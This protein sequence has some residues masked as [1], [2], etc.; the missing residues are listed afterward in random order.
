MLKRPEGISTEQKAL[1]INLDDNI[2]GTIVEIG[3]GQEVA[4]QFFKAGAAA[5]TIAKTSSAYDMTVSDAIYGKAGRY[6]SRERVQQ[7][8]KHE[9]QL[10]LDRLAEVRSSTSTYFSYAATVSA[11]NFKGDNE[12][13]GW[14]GLRLQLRPGEDPC[15]IICHV[16]MLDKTNELQSLALGTLGVNLIHSAFNH[17]NNPHWLIESLSDNLGSDRIEVDLIEFSGPGFNHVDNRITNLHL[18]TAWLTRAVLFDSNGNPAVPR[19]LLYKKP[20]AVMRGSFKPPTLAHEDMERCGIEQLSA[21]EDLEPSSIL[22]LAEVSMS[23]VVNESGL[24]DSDFLA[25]V[26]LA[27]TMGYNVLISNYVRYFSVRSWIRRHTHAAIAIL[28]KASDIKNF[29][30]D[31]KLYDGLEGG[32]LEGLGKLFADNTNV[33]VYPVHR[34]GKKYSLAEVDFPERLELV[35]EQL[36]KNGKLIAAEGYDENRLHLSAREVIQQIP[37]GNG[38]WESSLSEKV[39]ALIKER[40]LFGYN[41]N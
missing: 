20:V 22:R 4:R 3:A 33:Y 9:F 19:D 37:E 10:C 34:D 6:V 15:E 39:A 11:R 31:D 8:L 25:R 30:F 1:S 32:V 24:D 7:M 26:D 18:V 5:G 41:S 2:Y 27:N 13:H 16:R 17:H 40:Q 29:L 35:A 28:M 14:I 36:I 12:C 23:Q 21:Q 38:G